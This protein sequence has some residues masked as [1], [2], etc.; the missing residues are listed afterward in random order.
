MKVTLKKVL[1]TDSLRQTATTVVS[2]YHL[3]EVTNVTI[4]V[5]PIYGRCVGSGEVSPRR[6]GYDST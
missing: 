6:G 1:D 2:R 3:R 4:S 5:P